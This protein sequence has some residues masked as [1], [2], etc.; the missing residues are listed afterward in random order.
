MENSKAR[1]IELLADVNRI[2]AALVTASNEVPIEVAENG[3]LV[4]RVD[5]KTFTCSMSKKQDDFLRELLRCDGKMGGNNVGKWIPSL[6]ER[7]IRDFIG[8]INKKL[9]AKTMPVCLCFRD[10]TI[11]I[12]W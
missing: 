1:L 5:S 4:V 12:L 7:A 8:N 2:V 3:G 6:K 10:W 9:A 11:S